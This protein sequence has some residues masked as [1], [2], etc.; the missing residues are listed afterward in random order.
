[1]V[2]ASKAKDQEAELL[3]K[4][5]D[6]GKLSNG[7]PESDSS[8]VEPLSPLQDKQ[9]SPPSANKTVRNRSSK[10]ESELKALKM[11]DDTRGPMTNWKNLGQLGKE[12]DSS[13]RATG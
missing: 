10:S 9:A 8:K 1:M 13:A 11:E 12:S 2:A 6:E 5:G 7:Q 3:K 4:D